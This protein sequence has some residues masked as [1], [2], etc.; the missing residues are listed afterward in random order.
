MVSQTYL[1]AELTGHGNSLHFHQEIARGSLFGG[2]IVQ[3][4]LT[5]GIVNTVVAGR[6]A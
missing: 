1:F 5:S 2:L 3:G 4:G 6:D